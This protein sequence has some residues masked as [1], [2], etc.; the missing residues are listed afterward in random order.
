MFTQ[1]LHVGKPYI[2]DRERLQSYLDRAMDTAWLTNDGPLVRELEEK[3]AKYLNV[4]NVVCVSSGTVGLQ[5]AAKATHLDKIIVMPSW[6]FPATAMAMTWLGANINFVDVDLTT[7][8]ASGTYVRIIGVHTWGNECTMAGYKGATIYDAAHA[9]APNWGQHGD[10]EVFSFH[11]T[12]FFHTVEGGCITTA[13]DELARDCRQMR[14]F[15]FEDGEV[16]DLGINGK[17]SEVHAAWGL[18]MFPDLDWLIDRN[19]LN[20]LDYFGGLSECEGID[21]VQPGPNYQY[22]VLTVEKRDEILAALHAEQVWA[23]KYFSPGV[24]HLPAYERDSQPLPNTDWLSAHNL[25]LPTGPSV[26]RGDI[27]K[28]CRIIRGVLDA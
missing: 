13:N 5:I 18:A 3:I 24:H 28:I 12:K 26:Y 19:T 27:T 6:T 1:P 25:V 11:A 15:G 22:I 4:R 9:F 21:L 17:M 23:R 20:Y 16:V 10:A 8:L 14:N 7:Q 2:P